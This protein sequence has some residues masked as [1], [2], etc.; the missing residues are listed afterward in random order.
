MV[1]LDLDG[2]TDLGEREIFYTNPTDPD[3]DGDGS[4]DGT[5]VLN[6]TNPLD[7]SSTL[8][9]P[10]VS[11]SGE[12][13]WA[14]YIVRMSG[15]IAF[16]LLY[17]VMFLG[18]TI[19]IPGLNKIFK[20][21]NSLNVHTWLSVQS[22][23]FVIIHGVAIL[24]DDFMK[25]TFLDVFV[26][27]S[28]DFKTELVA[29]GIIGFYLMV[30]LIVSSY[31]RKHMPYKVWRLIHYANIILFVI[32]VIHSLYLGT[33]MKNEIVRNIFIGANALMAV[34]IAVNVLFRLK[35]FLARKS[36]QSKVDSEADTQ[37]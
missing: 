8:N 20:P 3:T 6:N 18:L 28:S 13:P 17:I 12:T 16:I 5:E 4:Y 32:V 23:L 25:F 2:L 22:L 33:D 26:P 19:R 37:E 35:T 11:V 31:L 27:F 36:N 1:D 21:I 7:S 15:V 34:L 24:F 10:E 30:V 9:V 29:L 14:W